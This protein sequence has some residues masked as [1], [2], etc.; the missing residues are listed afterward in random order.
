MPSAWIEHIKEF[1]KQKNLSY[2]CALSDPECSR[3]Y[4]LKYPPKT[5]KT[6]AVPVPVPTPTPPPP[7]IA[8]EPTGNPKMQMKRIEIKRPASEFDFKEIEPPKPKPEETFEIEPV[9]KKRIAK[10][11]PPNEQALLL[12]EKGFELEPSKSASPPSR[13]NTLDT[14]IQMVADHSPDLPADIKKIKD[15]YI[16]SLIEQK[17]AMTLNESVAISEKYDKLIYED[18]GI[19]VPKL[20][21]NIG[22]VGPRKG[23]E[24]LYYLLVELRSFGFKHSLKFIKDRFMRLKRDSLM[25]RDV[26][27]IPYLLGVIKHIIDKM[28]NVSLGKSS[29]NAY[30]LKKY[31]EDK[32]D[33]IYTGMI[34]IP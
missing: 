5:K 19:A 3:T 7:L 14:L 25:Q 22:I 4:R 8:A 11:A 6:K 24:D 15:L 16:K 26:P 29:V 13:T 12:K 23:G 2:G 33:E 27:H 1:A 34:K 20:I 17:N 28:E 32:T 31:G 10:K 30:L 21:K 18:Y 9:K